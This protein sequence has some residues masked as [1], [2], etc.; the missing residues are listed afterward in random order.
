M[1]SKETIEAW[2]HLYDLGY[3][4][5]DPFSPEISVAKLKLDQALHEF[6]DANPPGK[7]VTFFA[8]KSEAIRQIKKRLKTLPPTSDNNRLV[9][10]KCTWPFS[11]FLR[12]E[13]RHRSSQKSGLI[14]GRPV[15]FLRWRINAWCNLS[16]LPFFWHFRLPLSLKG[17]SLAT[18][19]DAL[20]GSPASNR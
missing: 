19:C 10:G 7:S 1:I 13:I 3:Q 18:R 15:H 8:F 6:Y 9:C 12:K 4:N 20:I 5:L 14:Q 17:G 2:A 16:Q 11:N